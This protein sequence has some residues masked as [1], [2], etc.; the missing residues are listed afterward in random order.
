MKEA[1]KAQSSCRLRFKVWGNII[2]MQCCYDGMLL[3]KTN[4]K[5]KLEETLY[6]SLHNNLSA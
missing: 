2:N 1:K 4:E 5:K 3:L 6:F